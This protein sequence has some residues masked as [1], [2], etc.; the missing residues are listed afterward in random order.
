MNPV[1]PEHNP[2]LQG[3]RAPMA[4]GTER[5]LCAARITDRLLPLV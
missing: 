1:F 4:V 3:M 2:M 5:T